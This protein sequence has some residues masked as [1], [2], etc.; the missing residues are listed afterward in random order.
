METI[1]ENMKCAAKNWWLSLILGILFIGFSLLLMFTPLESY[2]ALSIA[3]SI[4]MFISGI[5]EIVFS[6]SNR[7]DSSVWGWYLAA[8][9][10]DLL[11]GFYLMFNP[12]V[13]MILIPFIVA[14]W[15]MFKGFSGIG[16]AINLQRYGAKNWGWAF[17]L[18]ILAIICSIAIIWQPVAGALSVVY[19][20]AYAFLF[21][22]IFRI[23]FSF[24]LKKLG[25][26]ED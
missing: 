22:G 9:I 26:K 11:I 3:F 8:G 7:K 6:I 16:N 2:I 18:G 10:I 15:L 13:S 19:M 5:F 12:G 1:Y 25:K 14:F 20:I 21:I 4:I 17:V 23:M 24:Q